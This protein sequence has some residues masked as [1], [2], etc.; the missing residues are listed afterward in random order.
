MLVDDDSPGEVSFAVAVLAGAAVGATRIGA[1]GAWV[2][3]FNGG[4]MMF[5]CTNATSFNV[6]SVGSFVP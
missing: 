5:R 3:D 6:E 4:D 1:G 2:Q